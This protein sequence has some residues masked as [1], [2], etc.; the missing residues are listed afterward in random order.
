MISL[1]HVNSRVALQGLGHAL[2]STILSKT[3]RNIKLHLIQMTL[4]YFL[5]MSGVYLAVFCLS[6]LTVITLDTKLL[7][8]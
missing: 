1:L 2:Q 7:S 3:Y 5:T 4:S 8:S 6:V